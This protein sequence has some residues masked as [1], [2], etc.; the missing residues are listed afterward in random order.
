MSAVTVVQQSCRLGAARCGYGFGPQLPGRPGADARGCRFGVGFA[1]EPV[2]DGAQGLAE[3]QGDQ[4]R[5]TSGPGDPVHD[6]RDAVSRYIAPAT[7]IRAGWRPPVTIG[8]D[9]MCDAR[10]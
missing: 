4:M 3:D 9:L 5:V 8:L 10:T 6:G 2:G 1:F 7:R